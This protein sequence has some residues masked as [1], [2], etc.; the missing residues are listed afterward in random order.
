MSRAD[1]RDARAWLRATYWIGSMLVFLALANL[2][3]RD[4]KTDLMTVSQNQ[5]VMFIEPK[6]ASD[7]LY[8]PLP[9]DR[10]DRL[11]ILFVGN[12]QSYAIMDFQPGDRPLLA[13]LSQFLNGGEETASSTF[14]VR[15]A[16]EANLR[17]SE[18]LVK[19][20]LTGADS[21]RRPDV[22]IGGVVLDGLRW[23][24]PRGGL[25]EQVRVPAARHELEE[26]ALRE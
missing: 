9:V 4:V 5:R 26:L 8:A 11:S 16:S 22:F 1:M 18:L 6:S 14:A 7:P 10:S 19:A 23:I 15:F 25:A 21:E 3:A 12:S 17:M 20:V 2:W 24:D 13:W